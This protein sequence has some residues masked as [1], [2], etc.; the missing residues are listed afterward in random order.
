MLSRLLF[1]L[2][3]LL[4]CCFRF[5]TPKFRE[6]ASSGLLA[7]F[8]TDPLG[9]CG[10]GWHPYEFKCRY[11]DCNANVSGPLTAEYPVFVTEWAPGFPQSNRSESTATISPKKIGDLFSSRM[12]QLS[13]TPHAPYV[14]CST[15]RPRLAGADWGLVLAIRWCLQSDGVQSYETS[16]L[17]CGHVYPQA[18]PIST[19]SASSPGPMQ[20]R[21]DRN[22]DMIFAPFPAHFLALHHPSHAVWYALIRAHADRMLI[23]TCDSTLYPIPD[24]SKGTV[25]LFPWVW[26]P[27][28]G[29]TSSTSF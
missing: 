23:G 28:T 8:P 5:G 17:L 25:Q 24:S 27:G 12:S 13:A 16:F 22:F 18:R 7:N 11:F 20:C 26:N 21:Y 9:N 15:R 29:T 2:L 3:L 10:A 4:F 19:R 1:L 6:I 14:V